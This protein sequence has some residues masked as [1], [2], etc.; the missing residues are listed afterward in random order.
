MW[1]F[2]AGQETVHVSEGVPH[3]WG[4]GQEQSLC[5]NVYV[6]IFNF[7]VFIVVAGEPLL[8]RPRVHCDANAI[9]SSS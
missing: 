2:V 8:G 9:A 3:F 5:L 1:C 7:I 4:G 6:Q